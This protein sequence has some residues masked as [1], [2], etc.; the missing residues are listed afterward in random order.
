MS[1]WI[2][3]RCFSDLLPG[4]QKSSTACQSRS[5]RSRRDC[6]RAPL[7][8]TQYAGAGFLL[9]YPIFVTIDKKNPY[10]FRF[11]VM[12]KWP[13][14]LL[15]AFFTVAKTSF[16]QDTLPKFSLKNV[17]N[18]RI[19]VEWRNTFETV[20]QISIQRSF[21]SLKNFKTILTVADPMLPA[22]GYMDTKAPNDHMFY[23]VYILLDKG[24]FLFSDTKKP[25]IDTGF[26]AGNLPLFNPGDPL[27]PKD[28]GWVS[29]KYIY[30]VKDG[31]VRISLPEDPGKKY[32]IKFFT[33]QDELL[34]ELKEIKE[35]NFKI[36]KSNFYQ[37]GWF[38]FE[39]YENG[40]LR[41]K[42]R[43]YLPREF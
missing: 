12:K 16:A 7:Q 35:R 29:S 14:L 3:G 11:P 26:A 6:T 22:N 28:E 27:M 42:N 19:L 30:I 1:P 38:K 2:R 9:P 13:L 33:F 4:K 15:I 24:A 17:G 23:R 25:V 21:D 36:D 37:A 40:L 10:P 39:L 18:N 43:F 41:E 20:K 34:F 8:E 5:R 32:S 31:Y